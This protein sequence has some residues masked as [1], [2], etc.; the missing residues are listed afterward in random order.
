[1]FDRG[2]RMIRRKVLARR[3]RLDG[4]GKEANRVDVARVLVAGPAWARAKVYTPW[5]E[6][7]LDLPLSSPTERG[8]DKR[9]FTRLTKRLRAGPPPSVAIGMACSHV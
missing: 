6:R 4:L 8:I 9:N 7:I 3:D 2:G 1:M 5:P